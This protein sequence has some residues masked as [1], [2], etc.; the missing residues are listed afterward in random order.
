LSGGRRRIA[1]SPWQIGSTVFEA[2]R[3]E[4]AAQQAAL[5]SIVFTPPQDGLDV[6]IGC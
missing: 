3:L 1:P 4:D 5:S 2:G 6:V